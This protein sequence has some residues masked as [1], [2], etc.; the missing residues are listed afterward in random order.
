M[1]I[2]M[3][4]SKLPKI[5]RWMTTGRCSA[6]SA[7]DVLQIEPLRQLVVELD[8][9][10][11]PLPADRVGD[12]EVDLRPVERAVAFVERVGLARPARAPA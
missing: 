1:S 2:A 11:L 9:R 7:P 5:A 6:L 12:V 4:R 10:A 3:K 8:R